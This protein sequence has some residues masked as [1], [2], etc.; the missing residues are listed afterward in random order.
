MSKNQA[1]LLWPQAQAHVWEARRL[2]AL[3]VTTALQNVAHVMAAGL[4]D[5][6]RAAGQLIEACAARRQHRRAVRALQQLDDHILR[7][8]GVFRGEI[9]EVARYGRVHER[10]NVVTMRRP[11]AQPAPELKQAA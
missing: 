8:I 4:R 3:A 7:D 10:T 5:I 2:R 6:G 9:P 1:H 11:A